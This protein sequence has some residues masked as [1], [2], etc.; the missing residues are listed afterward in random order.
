MKE[1]VGNRTFSHKS[2]FSSYWSIALITTGSFWSQALGD[3]AVLRLY[4]TSELM[5]TTT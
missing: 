5:K 4:N 3:V 2:S 1:K